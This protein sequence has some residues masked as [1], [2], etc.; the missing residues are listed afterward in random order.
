MHTENWPMIWSSHSEDIC[1]EIRS[2]YGNIKI[3]LKTKNEEHFLSRWIEH[4]LRIVGPGNIIIMD[5]G[6]DS[7]EVISLYHKF[8]DKIHVYRYFGIHNYLHVVDQFPA[9][10]RALRDSCRHYI[11]LDTDEFLYFRLG[12]RLLSNESI[13]SH[14]TMKADYLFPGM[15]LPNYQGCDDIF[16]IDDYTG[17]LVEGLTW[18]KPL[19]PASL[20][21]EGYVNHNVQLLNGNSDVQTEAGLFI[22]HL[23]RMFPKQRIKQNIQKLVTRKI[24]RSPDEIWKLLETKPVY[25]DENANLYLREIENLQKVERW[26]RPSSTPKGCIQILE[27]NAPA[28]GDSQSRD[29]FLRLENDFQS[30]WDEVRKS[31]NRQ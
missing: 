28:F 18:G 26:D 31:Q 21:I 8:G 17:R 6:S 11:F 7:E 23:T 19:I 13:C 12:D 5:N 22:C 1:S 2:T 9:L 30:Y 27:D 16:F 10:Y 25:D 14:I 24:I 29:A 3:V 20:R 15:W 4:H